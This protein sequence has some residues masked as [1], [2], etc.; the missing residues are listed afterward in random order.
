VTVQPPRPQTLRPRSAAK[1]ID[2]GIET[3]RLEPGALDQKLYVRGIGTVVE[4][5]LKGGNGQF[6]LVSVK[7]N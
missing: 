2:H 7:H 5:S 3:T 4:E 6:V 1:I